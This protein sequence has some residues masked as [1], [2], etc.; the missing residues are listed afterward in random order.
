MQTAK[1]GSK[2]ILTPY[3]ITSGNEDTETERGCASQEVF[4]GAGA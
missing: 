1:T 2:I 4:T 3:S